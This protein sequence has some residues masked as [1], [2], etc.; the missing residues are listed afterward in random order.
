MRTR[1]YN[2]KCIKFVSCFQAKLRW[3]TD[4][5]G[6]IHQGYLWKKVSKTVENRYWALLF[7]DVFLLSNVSSPSR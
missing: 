7:T 4:D 6:L 3:N 1:S 5:G 2:E